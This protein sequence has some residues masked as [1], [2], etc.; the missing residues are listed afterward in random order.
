MPVLIGGMIW[1]IVAFVI[2]TGTKNKTWKEFGDGFSTWVG[3][4]CGVGSA[5]FTLASPLALVYLLPSCEMRTELQ[6]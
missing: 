6:T 4:V 3:C 5:I 1:L 2:Q